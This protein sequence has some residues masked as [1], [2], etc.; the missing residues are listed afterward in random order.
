MSLPKSTIVNVLA[1]DLSVQSEQTRSRFEEIA[2][3]AD[4][5]EAVRQA[6]ERHSAANDRLAK[7]KTTQAALQKRSKALF[8]RNAEAQ[9]AIETYLIEDGLSGKKLEIEKLAREVLLAEAEQRAVTRAV[10]RL[11]ENDIP[12]AFLAALR[13]RAALLEARSAEL[14]K[15]ARERIEKSIG[16]LGEA[17]EFEGGITVDIKSTLSGMLQTRADELD[18]EAASIVREAMEYERRY[19]E[20]AAKIA[21]LSL[22]A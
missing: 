2:A 7:L 15:I 5:T 12:Q 19:Q 9:K 4:Q 3:Q 11:V 8:D 10:A 14:L 18:R 13:T 21:A 17:A 22:V 20:Q 1:S 6:I 16:M